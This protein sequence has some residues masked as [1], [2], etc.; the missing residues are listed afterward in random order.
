MDSG[1][2]DLVG[3]PEELPGSIGSLGFASF[4]V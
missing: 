2:P 3:L 4:R 1:P